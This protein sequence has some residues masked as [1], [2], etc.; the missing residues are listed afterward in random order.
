M[1]AGVK[2]SCVMDRERDRLLKKLVAMESPC[3]REVPQNAGGLKNEI[4]GKV[5]REVQWIV[6]PYVEK[7]NQ[8]L[9]KHQLLMEEH[10]KDLKSTEENLR[11]VEKEISDE[12]ERLLMAENKIDHLS[13]QS[14]ELENKKLSAVV[15]ELMKVKW[16]QIDEIC[17]RT[18]TDDDLLT[19][20]ICGHQEKRGNYEKKI[21]ECIYNGGRLE[22]YVCPECGVIFGPTKFDNLTQAEKDED[23]Y[24]HY[25]GFHE[26]DSTEK[27]IKAFYMLHPDK[28]GVYLN[29]G[30]GSWSKSIQ[31]IREAGYNVYGYEPYAEVSDNPYFITDVE[32]L[33]RMRFDGIYSND[34]IEHLIHPVEDFIFM[35]SLLKSPESKMS[36]STSCYIYKHEITR[37]HTHFFTGRSL[38][39][40]CEKAG[41]K[42]LDC[43]N[44]VDTEADFY[45]YVYGMIENEVNYMPSMYVTQESIKSE[46]EI[47]LN[48]NGIMFGPYLNSGAL[49]YKWQID[50]DFGE[51]MH[52]LNY[53]ITSDSGHRVLYKGILE[54]GKNFISYH[55]DDFTDNVEIVIENKSEQPIRIT[56]VALLQ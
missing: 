28:N 50:I 52:M 46:K 13:M 2:G 26:G 23:Y 43:K 15:R 3:L 11:L 53:R 45:C 17:Q 5:E 40:L 19:C 10:N 30:C 47:I 32:K 37:F 21:S 55:L 20:K 44:E 56:K 4:K 6:E 48:K 29:Y 41:L 14:T 35:K 38:E 42:I 33:K 9:K 24:V 22:R 54:N 8:R 25:L 39:V 51:N 12:K 27:E 1:D 49:D 31:I 36:H 18:E 34:L 7:N 16:R